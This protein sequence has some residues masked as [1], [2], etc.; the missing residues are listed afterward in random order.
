MAEYENRPRADEK[1]F[2]SGWLKTGDEGYFDEDG[3][4]FITGRI[5]ETINRGGEKI[6][7]REVDEVLL[8]HPAVAQAVV[9]A[10]PHSELGEDVGAAIVLREGVAAT[11]MELQV[12]ASKQLADFK[13]PRRVIFV[14]EI[15]KGPTGKPVRIGLAELLDVP[16]PGRVDRR[17]QTEYAAPRT[18][19]EKTLAPIWTQA[20]GMERVG[21]HDNFFELG[22]NSLQ[23][24][25]IISR[26]WELFHVSLPPQT[27]FEAP[28]IAALAE[29]VEALGRVER[30][31]AKDESGCLVPL[32]GGGGRPFF[33]VP[34]GGGGVQELIIYGKLIHLLDT[35]HRV[36]GLR[37]RGLDGEHPPHANVETMAADY[38]DEV[39]GLQPDGPYLLGGEC[40]GGGVAFEMA[41]QLRAQGRQVA[42]LVLMNAFLSGPNRDPRQTYLARQVRR[43]EHHARHLRTLPAGRR[44]GHVARSLHNLQRRMLPLTREQRAEHHIYRVRANYQSMLTRHRPRSKYPG[45]LTLLVTADDYRADSFHEWKKLATGG[46]VIDKVPGTHESY[47]AEHAKTTAEGGGRHTHAV[48]VDERLI[49]AL[50]RRARRHHPP[51]Q[52]GGPLFGGP[53]RYP[54]SVRRHRGDHLAGR[55]PRGRR[56]GRPRGS[57]SGPDFGRGRQHNSDRCRHVVGGRP[58][59]TGGE[60][61]RDADRPAGEDGQEWGKIRT[62]EPHGRL[63]GSEVPTT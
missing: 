54:L 31:V 32:R 2:S 34:G 61:K 47:L 55:R 7:P 16:A 12:H 25:Q 29:Q 62:R 63:L 28:T 13:V 24:A 50:P 27:L 49:G 9:F 46:V 30:P 41:R 60:R 22:G 21:V 35:D 43:V 14:D 4:L 1:A 20:F 15:P 8:D 37:A 6:S 3:Y 26:V 42:L 19:L 56:G 23:L 17:E 45:R 10:V 33:L 59:R 44:L 39:R 38:V 48:N 40:I 11:S 52:E 57:C 51:H 53:D 36:Y 18:S 58:G 5:K